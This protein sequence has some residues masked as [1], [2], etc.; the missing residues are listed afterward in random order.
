MTTLLS[1]PYCDFISTVEMFSCAGGLIKRRCAPDYF[2]NLRTREMHYI[3]PCVID[4]AHGYGHSD[5]DCQIVPPIS[6]CIPVVGS[7]LLQFS[8]TGQLNTRVL[9]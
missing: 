1:K 3:M 5:V 8:F 6:Y 7:G 4:Q 9:K 2:G